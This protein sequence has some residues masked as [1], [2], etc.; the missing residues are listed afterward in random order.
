MKPLYTLPEI[1][2]KIAA[3][4]AEISVDYVGKHPLLIGVLKGATVFMAHLLVHI[5]IDCEIDFMTVSSYKHRTES[6][7]LKLVQDLDTNIS[8]RHVILVED[9]FDT[10]KTADFVIKYLKSRG[11]ASV[12]MAVFVNK[13]HSR[14]FPIPDPRYLCFSYN[15]KPFLIGFGFDFG[16]RYRNLP[17]VYQLEEMDKVAPVV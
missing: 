5:Y 3:I 1:H 7:E 17:G 11:A 16:E 13:E 14:V 9:I 10:G 4:G 15:D 12:E 2:A 6:G 8:G